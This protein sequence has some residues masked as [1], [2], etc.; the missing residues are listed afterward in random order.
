MVD[1]GRLHIQI[2]MET[3]TRHLNPPQAEKSPSIETNLQ[4]SVLLP[5]GMTKHL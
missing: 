3:R 5:A 2:R 1:R 4:I